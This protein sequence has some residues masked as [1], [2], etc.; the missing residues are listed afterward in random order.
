MPHPRPRP[1]MSAAL[2]LAAVLLL[3]GCAQLDELM[4]MVTGGEDAETDDEVLDATAASVLLEP[5]DAPGPNPFTD[6]A[7]P[8]QDEVLR[9]FSEQGA[10]ADPGAQASDPAEALVEQ[11]GHFTIDGSTPGLFGG[12]GAEGS[13]DAEQ[14]AT[15]LAEEPEKA[16]AWSEVLGI[17]PQGIADYLDDTTAV[18][19]GADTRV[20]NHGYA[21]GRVSPRE[22]VL[23]RGS[24]VLVDDRGVPVVRCA[25]GNPLLPPTVTPDEVVEGEPWESYRP[26]EVLVIE[27]SVE[28]VEVF[29]VTDVEDGTRRERPTGTRGEQDRPVTTT[30]TVDEE[31][32]ED[33]EEQRASSTTDGSCGEIISTGPVRGGETRTYEV[34]LTGDDV[35]CDDARR[36]AQAYA[37]S[38]LGDSTDVGQ[39]QC[40]PANARMMEEGIAARC[41][42]ADSVVDLLFDPDEL[43]VGGPAQDPPTEEPDES[44]QDPSTVAGEDCGTLSGEFGMLGDMTAETDG[45]GLVVRGAEPCE[46]AE[47]VA[48]AF[49]L[50]FSEWL[51]SDDYDV[52]AMPYET[53]ILGWQCNSGSLLNPLIPD[54]PLCVLH[55]AEIELT[56][57]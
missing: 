34:R 6:R 26:G 21:D 37:D 19:L 48:T 35:D 11:D 50:D 57:P 29:E 8:E 38:H 14:V 31:P 17:T 39:W 42:F 15:F 20:L 44:L 22:A 43:G 23:Q 55:N 56:P 30:E 41:R 47:E 3:T 36:V 13:C 51:I 4:S 16:A 7:D 33:E 12:T 1:T 24:A 9:L 54:P 28:P 53:D 40:G 25:C 27:P 5:A 52:N 49:L 45:I 18:Q 32:R 2:L 46:I 10:V